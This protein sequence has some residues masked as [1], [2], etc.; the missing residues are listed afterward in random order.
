MAGLLIIGL[1]M[2]LIGVAL[3]FV[4]FLLEFLKSLKKT[5]NVKTGG[6]VLIGPFPIIF[7]DRDLVKYSM[8]LLVMMAI[9]TVVLLILSGV[10]V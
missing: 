6:A 5:A 9:L 3:V 1:T 7:G 2:I 4:G 8:I 10:L